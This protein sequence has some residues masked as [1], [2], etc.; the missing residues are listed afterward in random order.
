MCCQS[1]DR[2]SVS[3]GNL[4]FSFGRPYQDQSNVC[5]TLQFAQTPNI[6]PLPPRM[7]SVTVRNGFSG[8]G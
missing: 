3:F 1:I 2:N 4:F 7:K 8:T 6:L 5:G